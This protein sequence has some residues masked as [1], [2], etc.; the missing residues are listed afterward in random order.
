MRFRTTRG[1][2]GS[3][4]GWNQAMRVSG[5]GRPLNGHRMV[6]DGEIA[7]GLIDPTDRNRR[8]GTI[9]W[10]IRRE[11][12]EPIWSRAFKDLGQPESYSS[13][14]L[15]GDR[16]YAGGG[17]RDGSSGFVQVLDARTGKLIATHELPA[18]VMECGLAAADGRLIVCCEDGTV[19]CYAKPN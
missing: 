9:M 19:V 8:S 1:R 17:K 16:L 14:I 12:R 6:V 4:H 3:T 10:S 11:E 7:Y 18:R 2:G 13:L 5:K 15:A